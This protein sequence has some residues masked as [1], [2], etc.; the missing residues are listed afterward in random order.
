[1]KLSRSKSKGRLGSMR[2]GDVKGPRDD[3]ASETSD[4]ESIGS[5]SSSTKEDSPK[6]RWTKF[7]WR[8]KKKDKSKFLDDSVSISDVDEYFDGTSVRSSRSLSAVSADN[9]EGSGDELE[10]ST[11]MPEQVTQSIIEKKEKEKEKKK[12]EAEER[13]RPAVDVPR[14]NGTDRFVSYFFVLGCGKELEPINKTPADVDPYKMGY[15]GEILDIFPYSNKE[16]PF[17]EHMW[18]F[19]QPQGLRLRKEPADPTCFPFILT[20]STGERL[21]GF[22]L[23]FSERVPAETLKSV[24]DSTPDHPIYAPKCICILSH[25]PF[26]SAF[27]EWSFDLFR[28]YTHPGNNVGRFLH[29]LEMTIVNF[30]MRTPLPPARNVRVRVNLG[31]DRL[32]AASRP[33][34]FPVVEFPLFHLF[35]LL[36]LNNSLKLFL[37]ILIE[38]KVVLLSRT[39]SLLTFVCETIQALLH[40]LNWPHV[41]VP[42]LPEVLIDFTYSPTPYILGLNKNY[43]GIDLNTI[44][45]DAVV[46]DLEEGTIQC[47][48][49][50]P[51]VTEPAYE[52]LRTDLQRCF[53]ADIHSLDSPS[54]SPLHDQSS[55]TS[56]HMNGTIQCIFFR[57]FASL[58]HNYRDYMLYIRVFRKPVT[59]FDTSRFLATKAGSSK[60]FLE[61]F[62]E[63]QAFSIFLDTQGN[64]TSNLLDEWIANQ[65]YDR[66]IDEI[67]AKYSPSSVG[68]DKPVESV[69]IPEMQ[70][71]PPL[72]PLQST[73]NLHNFEFPRLNN[74]LLEKHFGTKTIAIGFKVPFQD[75]SIAIPNFSPGSPDIEMCSAASSPVMKKKS[76]VKEVI[77]L[78]VSE[79]LEGRVSDKQTELQLLDFFKFDFARV[80][81]AKAIL[82]GSDQINVQLTTECF[83]QLKE[84]LDSAMREA[85]NNGDHHSPRYIVPSIFTYCHIEN[86]AE[87]LMRRHEQ[88]WQNNR[89][90]EKAYFGGN[91]K[92]GR[93]L[94]ENS[95]TV[96]KSWKRMYGDIRTKMNLFEGMSTS[97]QDAIINTEDDTVFRLLSQFAFNMINLGVE[98]D[99][100][101]R[102]L[103]KMTSVSGMKEDQS[104]LLFQLQANM[105]R[106]NDLLVEDDPGLNGHVAE[107]NTKFKKGDAYVLTGYTTKNKENTASE[108][109][110]LFDQFVESKEKTI[111]GSKMQK[112]ISMFQKQNMEKRKTNNSEFNTEMRDDYTIKTMRG[113]EEGV[114]AVACQGATVASGSCDSTVRLWNAKN[115]SCFAVLND[116]TGWVNVMSF[117][118]DTRLVTGSYDKTL[119]LW[120]VSR[121]SKVFTIRGHKLSISCVLIKEQR[122]VLSGSFDNTIHLWDTR[123]HRKPAASFTGH[124]GAI[125]CIDANDNL[126]LSGSR[127]SKLR[128]WDLRSTKCVKTMD[129]HTDW[130]FSGSSDATVKIYDT[131]GRLERS[132]EGHTGVVNSIHVDDHHLY[133]GSQDS[134]VKQWDY[135]EGSCLYT[136][137]AH[138]DEVVSIAPLQNKVVSCSHDQTIRM[139][140]PTSKTG[141]CLNGHTSRINALTSL[142]NK[143]VSGS[144]DG[145]VKLWEFPMEI[146]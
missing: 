99:L 114:L 19:C 141:R 78:F 11:S 10:R 102:F 55:T 34:H 83:M 82:P 73:T 37:C 110:Q 138:T 26:Y 119:K 29:S 60:E 142:E 45:Q 31:G 123:N 131:Q 140:D 48:R 23:I 21:H 16:D 14:P 54:F 88:I 121:G 80:L 61:S 46:V 7:T 98:S 32:V 25:W 47:P 2:N 137:E 40:P 94:T 86:G 124:S 39:Y 85:S 71:S 68:R 36:G 133:T 75:S 57:F 20:S 130:I 62:M 74:L 136:W 84:V 108:S 52:T 63:T 77:D 134:T 128:L 125:T 81:F 90:W 53:H 3:T 59:I 43:K 65:V 117:L 5:L 146:R 103:Y 109:V 135:L 112:M 35:K 9:I 67:V 15:K 30:T 144:W 129:E 79:C 56:I 66:E 49:P 22:A 28:K 38:E 76:Q 118:D 139:W 41:Y 111:G 97:D 24:F 126:L 106:A 89:F 17:P 95:E 143:I 113:H 91:E 64:S 107:F 127:D 18:M 101:R 72:P 6:N 122:F 33:L 96:S 58:M 104:K 100:T 105:S 13:E 12:K 69:T 4:S 116:H 92:F 8:S 1:M 70:S 51:E 115:G 120:D 93:K 87:T 132:L 42:I 145:T 50:L 44:K 27:R